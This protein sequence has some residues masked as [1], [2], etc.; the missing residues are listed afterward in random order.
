MD[1]ET[2]RGIQPPGPGTHLLLGARG[3]H[4]RGAW[5]PWGS[6]GP[7]RWSSVVRRPGCHAHC[8]PR[9]W[10]CDVTAQ[11]DFLILRPPLTCSPPSPWLH[12]LCAKRGSFL[13]LSK[14]FGIP[15]DTMSTVSKWPQGCFSDGHSVPAAASFLSPCPRT[16]P[17]PSWYPMPCPSLSQA[18]FL[19]L[20]LLLLHHNNAGQP[21]SH[22][23]S[24]EC[25]VYANYFGY[26]QET[27]SEVSPRTSCRPHTIMHCS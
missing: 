7:G 22:L 14:E 10:A 17:H 21:H 15:R 25:V 2:Q 16:W 8:P 18:G 1:L 9:G 12:S 24:L 5:S 19:P 27:D 23:G 26:H 20:D 3:P 6:P 11:N 13:F 4:S